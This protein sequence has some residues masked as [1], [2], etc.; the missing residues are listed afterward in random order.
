MID[1]HCHIDL[2]PDP[3][4]VLEEA[5]RR[6]V[7]ILAVTTSPKAWSG[8]KRLI[9]SRRRVRMALGLH[10]EVVGQRHMEV[11][12]LEHLIGETEYVGEIGLDGSP[13]MKSSYA[14]QEAALA[15]ILRACSAAGGR[16]LTL[17]SRRAAT[18]VLDALESAPGSGVP[19]LHW[20]S[21][22]QKELERA[23]KLGCWFSVGPM[24]LKSAK[25]KALAAMMPPE[26][27]LT[28]TDA[29]FAQ[30]DG[31]PLMPWD[32]CLAYPDLAAIWNCDVEM[33]PARLGA[34]LR[35]LLALRK[36]DELTK[37]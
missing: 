13:H 15:R 32:V 10:P 14:L 12:L 25:G 4:A 23:I 31:K 6:G 37:S 30:I 35:G 16:I 34:N 27:V 36:M 29:P 20:F 24:M 28:E 26:R 19:I 8:T 18:G 22:S 17:H 11:P 1:F 21:G 33:I 5:D 3:I 2:Y 7:Y 9:G